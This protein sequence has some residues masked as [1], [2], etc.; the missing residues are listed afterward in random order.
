[1]QRVTTSRCMGARRARRRFS[2]G[3]NARLIHALLQI[4]DQRIEIVIGQMKALVGFVHR[5]AFVGARSPGN[6]AELVGQQTLKRSMLV[7]SKVA[8]MRS[9]ERKLAVASSTIFAMPG[10][11]PNRGKACL[12]P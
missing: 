3:R 5:A 9:S 12:R 1:M 6:D 2:S 7:L 4:F 10:R 11:S 8:L